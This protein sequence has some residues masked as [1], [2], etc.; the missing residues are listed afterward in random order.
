MLHHLHR[1]P[2]SVTRSR[3]DRRLRVVRRL[4]RR[5]HRPRSSAR[6]SFCRATSL[7]VF[8]KG[9]AT[10]SVRIAHNQ[11]VPHCGPMASVLTSPWQ[12]PCCGLP[13]GGFGRRGCA[14]QVVSDWRE[15]WQTRSPFGSGSS[16]VPPVPCSAPYQSPGGCALSRPAPAVLLN[17]ASTSAAMQPGGSDIAHPPGGR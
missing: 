16:R 17:Q 6:P 1:R 15:P 9:S 12:E 8:G 4:S 10:K 3:E 7:G 2:G 14:C 13:C 5:P 11:A